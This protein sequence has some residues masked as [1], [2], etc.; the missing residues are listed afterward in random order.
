MMDEPKLKCILKTAA[1]LMGALGVCVIGMAALMF[2]TM[3]ISM[4]IVTFVC[5][6]LNTDIL[7]WL[8]LV[9]L[10][11]ETSLIGAVIICYTHK[12]DK[13]PQIQPNDIIGE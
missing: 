9:L 5:G 3:Y 8:M 1:I 10:L 4:Q 13:T 11:A 6:E 12:K 7:L 2:F